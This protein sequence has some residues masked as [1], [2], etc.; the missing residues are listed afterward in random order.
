MLFINSTMTDLT[1]DETDTVQLSVTASGINKENFVYEWRKRDND[2][3]LKV[4]G[5]DQKVLTIP[6]LLESDEGTYFC[7]VTNN[8]SRSMVSN[9]IRIIVQGIHNNKIDRLY[10]LMKI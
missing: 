1:K 4:S 8:W 5:V 6:K 3:P 9:D 7:T 10:F 2:L